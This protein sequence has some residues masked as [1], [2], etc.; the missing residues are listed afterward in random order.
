MARIL[1]IGCG[2]RGIE[3]ARALQS[4]GHAVRGTTRSSERTTEL[5]TAGIESWVGDPDRIGEIHYSMENATILLWNLASA[6]GPTQSHEAL[7]GTRLQM[8]LERT[9][10]STVR[11]VLYEAEGS[12]AEEF[13]AAGASDVERICSRNEIPWA[14][15][16][17][18][19][20]DH[21]AWVA[22][23]K[24]QIDGLLERER[25]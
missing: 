17:A 10:D 22:E 1:I 9:I 5:E 11:G 14:L 4:D 2:C 8:M 19:P 21:A 24:L 20:L 12:V 6:T 23:A 25:G 13:L 15:L 7:H 3:L 18:D 16:K